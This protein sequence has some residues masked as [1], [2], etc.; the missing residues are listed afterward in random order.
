MQ[1]GSSQYLIKWEGYPPSFNTWEPE[2]NILCT[3]LLQKFEDDWNKDNDNKTNIKAKTTKKVIV[4]IK[5][6]IIEN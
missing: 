6:I 4:I 5:E 1:K 2:E 3:E